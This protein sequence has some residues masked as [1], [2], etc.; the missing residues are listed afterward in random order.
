MVQINPAWVSPAE[1]GIR[2]TANRSSMKVSRHI[3]HLV[4]TANLRDDGRNPT[5]V[6][7]LIYCAFCTISLLDQSRVISSSYACFAKK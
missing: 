3:S 7:F 4:C 5:G 2:K 1:T 6:P